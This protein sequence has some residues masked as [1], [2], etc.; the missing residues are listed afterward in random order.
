MRKISNL[1]GVRLTDLD[2]TPG[3]TKIKCEPKKN[4][5]SFPKFSNM[6][7]LVAT[8]KQSWKIECAISGTL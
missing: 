8:T 4:H 6:A 3:L 5:L 7:I 2:G 1:L